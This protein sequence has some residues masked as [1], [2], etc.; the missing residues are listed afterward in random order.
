MSKELGYFD[1][2]YPWHQLEIGDSFIAAVDSRRRLS[3]NAN[4]RY[5]PKRFTQQIVE[6][7]WLKVKRI[8]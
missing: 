6:N 7:G 2:P 8:K 1:A 5:A 3:S 4:Q